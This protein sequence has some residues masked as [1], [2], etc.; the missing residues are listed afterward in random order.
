MCSNGGA[1]VGELADRR[2]LTA[3][4]IRAVQARLGAAKNILRDKACVFATGSF[5]RGEA[6]AYSDLDL[7]IVGRRDGRQGFDGK[8]GSLLARLDEIC[9]KADLVEAARELNFPVFSQDG[10]YLTHHSVHEFTKTLG[11]PE[12]DVTNTFTAR[13]LLMLESCPLL[14]RKVY[15]EIIK[16]VIDAY[17]RD[18][19]DHKRN[20]MP[21]FL[22]NDI[23][24]LWRTFCV[25]Y[26]ARTERVPK[27]E[28]AKGKL[29]NYKLKHSRLLTCFSGLLYLLGIYVT[30][31]TVHP[32]DARDMVALTPTERFEWLLDRREFNKAQ[33]SVK[34]V[35]ARYERFLE[36]TN[37]PEGRL[38]DKFMYKKTS[39]PLLLDASAFG[40]SVYRVLTR[41]GDG[42]QFYRL[43]VV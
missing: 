37:S 42:N 3:S 9:V 11:T 7:F 38:V 14:E 39:E 36:T 35:L 15:E 20:F 8:E 10:R 29:K 26:E 40:D 43:L 17:W 6:S 4:R 24:R 32:S 33:A 19:R 21:A 31:R 13:L 34:E 23:L 12:D 28:R 41:I 18:Y 2:K 25:N 27:L 16:E 30:Q 5:G 1:F 22:A